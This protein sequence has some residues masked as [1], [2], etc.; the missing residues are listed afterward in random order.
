MQHI[1]HA[2]P[3]STDES[4]SGGERATFDDELDMDGA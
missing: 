1:N 2:G 4:A 3:G